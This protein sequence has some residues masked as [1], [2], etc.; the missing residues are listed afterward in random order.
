M[1]DGPEGG[2]AGGP[3]GGT[4]GCPEGGMAGCAQYGGGTGKGGATRSPS[5]PQAYSEVSMANQE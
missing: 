2:T 1:A 3:E 5:I 4:A